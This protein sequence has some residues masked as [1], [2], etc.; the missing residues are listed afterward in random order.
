[1]RRNS[2]GIPES[3]DWGLVMIW[4]YV[5]IPVVFFGGWLYA[6]TLAPCDQIGWVPV[7]SLPSRCI[8]GAIR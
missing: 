8:R 2:A 1:V 3:F 4:I 6:L 5:A 7:T